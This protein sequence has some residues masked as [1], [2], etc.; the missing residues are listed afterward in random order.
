VSELV[1]SFVAQRAMVRR[2]AVSQAY[3]KGSAMAER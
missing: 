2:D 3:L 1:G